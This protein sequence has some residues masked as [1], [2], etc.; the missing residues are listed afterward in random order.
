MPRVPTYTP[1]HREKLPESPWAS[2]A[3][4]TRNLN[5][6]EVAAE[7]RAHEAPRKE[8]ERLEQK[9]TWMIETVAEKEEVDSEA[10]RTGK[11][12]HFF[13]ILELS[14]GKHE[15]LLP[16]LRK[17]KGRVVVPGNTG[18]DETGLAAIFADAASSASR[19]EASKLGDATALLPHCGG[20][21]SDAPGAYTQALLYGDGRIDPVDIW[22]ILPK[23]RQ[24]A[25]W[26]RYR[27]P[28]CRLRLALYGHP[29]AGVL[30]ERKCRTCLE[31]V[32]FEPIPGW[33]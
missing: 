16:E 3:L 12:V 21:Q 19:I 17:F 11:K 20:E 31:S 33:E 18:Q 23:W 15:E 7:P 4:V 1:A 6:R 27:N 5:K 9:Q 14:P 10:I 28:V 29:L 2:P 22:I 30:W 13:N 24:P 32:G 8:Y 26:A 25:S